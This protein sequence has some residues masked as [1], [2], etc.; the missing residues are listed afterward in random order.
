MVGNW[1]EEEKTRSQN[2]SNKEK[3]S[4]P[5]LENLFIKVKQFNKFEREESLKEE[6]IEKNPLI[7]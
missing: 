2:E 6:I 5:S 4:N 7:D 3:N 1:V